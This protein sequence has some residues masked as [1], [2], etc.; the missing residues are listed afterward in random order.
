MRWGIVSGR[1]ALLRRSTEIQPFVALIR[2]P[3]LPLSQNQIQSFLTFQM[4][5]SRA[6]RILGKGKN[7][8]VLK[9]KYRK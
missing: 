6:A 5:G 4:R 9:Y 2:P 1:V 3:T 8:K 7:N